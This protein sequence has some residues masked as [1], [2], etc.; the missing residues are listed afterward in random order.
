MTSTRAT[1]EEPEI[2]PLPDGK[3]AY[4]NGADETDPFSDPSKLVMSQ[5]FARQA[6]VERLLTVVPVRKPAKH[7]FVR[8]HPDPEFRMSPAG[9]IELKE[10]REMYLVLPHLAAELSG[11]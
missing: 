9:I 6:G 2:G 10:E 11:E 7:D 4:P 1:A 8:V 3:G 5:D